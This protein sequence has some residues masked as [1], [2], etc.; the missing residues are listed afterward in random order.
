MKVLLT[1]AGGFIGQRVHRT[2]TDDGHKV[3]PC[4]V[5]DDILSHAWVE[6]MRR[7][8]FDRCIHLAA[9]KYATTAEEFPEQVADLNIRGTANVVRASGC[10]VILASTCKAADACTVYGASKLI[11]E[12]I[13]LNANGVVIRLV[14]VLGSTG[15]VLPIWEGIEGPLPVTDCKR[16]WISEKRAVGLFR[17]ALFLGSGRYA[18]NVPAPS[19][20]AEVARE[21]YPGRSLVSVPLRRGDRPVERLVGEYEKAVPFGG[22]ER[23][24]DCWGIG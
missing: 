11:A 17:H 21:H 10:P 16:M 12:R 14:N 5:A 18:P 15:S 7:Q 13:V 6:Q 2:L 9:H 20:V 24:V 8:T 19:P 22:L 3:V 4:D 1:G 23:I